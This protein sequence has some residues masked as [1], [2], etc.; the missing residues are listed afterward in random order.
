MKTRKQVAEAKKARAREY[1]QKNKD[2][3]KAA[4]KAYRERKRA[5]IAAQKAKYRSDNLEEILEK[6]AIKREQKREEINAKN[7]AYY[8]HN[9][10]KIKARRLQKRIESGEQIKPVMKPR[11]IKTDFGKIYDVYDGHKIDA[12]NYISFAELT[13]PL[14]EKEKKSLGKVID[15]VCSKKEVEYDF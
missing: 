2:R 11:K 10:E 1:Y 5:E 3:S 9:K 8:H 6:A 7:R 15:R 12:M 14:T 13:K 4:N